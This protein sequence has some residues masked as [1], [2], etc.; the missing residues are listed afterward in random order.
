VSSG[1]SEGADHNSSCTTIPTLASTSITGISK[2][3]LASI[4]G[5]H[6]LASTSITSTPMLASTSITIILESSNTICLLCLGHVLLVI[7]HY[8]IEA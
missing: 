2:L 6:K 4:T 5:I 8:I 3:A 7:I 1:K